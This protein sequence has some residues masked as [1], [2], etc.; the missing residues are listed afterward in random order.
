MTCTAIFLKLL[1]TMYN[2]AKVL[3][4]YYAGVYVCAHLCVMCS[5]V[6]RTEIG[7]LNT[8]FNRFPQGWGGDY[9]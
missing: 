8:K 6:Y 4:E 1:N 7:K 2:M 3:F 5:C 9:N